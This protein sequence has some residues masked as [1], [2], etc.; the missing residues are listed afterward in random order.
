MK[1]SIT[2]FRDMVAEAVR[3]TVREAK[4]KP[5]DVAPRSEESIAAERDRHVRGMPGYAHG[6][7]LDM[8]KP[9]GK[10]N[11]AKRQGAANM[12]NWTSESKRHVESIRALVR[13]IVDEEIRVIRGR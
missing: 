2:E 11:L 10:D 1:V 8:S 3:R 13:M 4:K 12:G 7:V 5:R 6:D 9:L